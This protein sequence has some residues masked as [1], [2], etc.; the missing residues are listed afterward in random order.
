VQI[1]LRTVERVCSACRS[2]ALSKNL[3]ILMSTHV[4]QPSTTDRG[5]LS[6][7]TVGQ[8]LILKQTEG[9]IIRVTAE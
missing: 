3:F 2:A 5:P 1:D 4:F 7:S 8:G 9:K 6:P